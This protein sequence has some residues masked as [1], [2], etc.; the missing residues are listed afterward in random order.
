MSVLDGWRFCPRCA[1][2]LVAGD[3]RVDCPSCGFVG[4]AN[5]APTASALCVDDRGRL[6]LVRRAIEP[7]RGHWDIPGGFLE[8]AEHPL[9]ALRRELAE[10]TGLEVEPVAFFGVEIDWYGEPGPGVPATL[11]LYWTARVVSGE[12]APA[13]DVSELRWFGPEE[14]P[15]PAELAFTNTVRVLEAWRQQQ[16]EG[17]G[18][19]PKP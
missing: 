4:Y 6:L 7:F 1:S 9:D 18:V 10:E 15:R 19:A 13:D 14:L 5:S 2:E 11:N 3:G 17:A 12:A 16:A 8:E